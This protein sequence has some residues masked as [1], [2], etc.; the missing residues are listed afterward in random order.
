MK[1]MNINIYILLGSK[2][3]I[4]VIGDVAM[5]LHER[6]LVQFFFMKIQSSIHIVLT[7]LQQLK[8][9]KNNYSKYITMHVSKKI[10]VD[11]TLLKS[12][13]MES[14]LND[15][16]ISL[17]M[18]KSKK[19]VKKSSSILLRNLVL[20]I[21]IVENAHSVVAVKIGRITTLKTSW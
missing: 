21:F 19:F 17:S 2:Y 8:R 7:K 6:E 15:S 20:T 18:Y 10:K 14:V 12:F 9:Y 3:I 4:Y 1:F 11:V 13:M 16:T 5:I